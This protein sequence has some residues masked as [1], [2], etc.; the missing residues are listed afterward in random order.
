[1]KKSDFILIG[2][3]LLVAILCL[4]TTKGNEK[5]EE[6]EYPLVL[7]GD[8]GLKQLTYNE[9]EDKV[10]KG[11]A[12]IVVIVRDGCGYCTMYTPIL[13]EVAKENK[14]PLYYID[15][16][17]LTSSELNKLE[18]TN[19]YL[20]RNS[21]WGTPTTLFMLGDRV[22]DALGGYVDKNGVLSF[23]EGKVVMGE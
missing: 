7:N 9:Y 11:E 16:A 17:D 2:I 13:E 12:F 23:L 21:K 1:M 3:V 5:L 14:L 20:K 15:I 19:K 6:V 22:L 8:A 18:T 10:N 4:F